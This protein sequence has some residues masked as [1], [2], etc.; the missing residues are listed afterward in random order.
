MILSKNDLKDCL[1]IELGAYRCCVKQ[2]Y[3]MLKM[4]IT[5]N[6]TLPK[7]EIIYSLRKYE[8]YLNLKKKSLF[9]KLALYFWHFI[10][11]NRQ[12]KHSIFIE[13]N[14]VGKGL[15]LMHPGFRKIPE[16]VKIGENCTILPM[17]LIGK[18][19]PGIDG[20]AVIGDNCYISTGVTILAP[21]KI[22]NNATIGAGAVV[23]KDVPDNMVVAGIPAR[24][25]H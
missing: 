11:R 16:F 1:S 13:P 7:H 4:F 18:R 10:F 23:T 8:Y 3:C 9:S 20:I 14:R 15:C 5:G 12:L 2:F 17:V 22:G 24:S 25:I 21:V 6:E 19:K